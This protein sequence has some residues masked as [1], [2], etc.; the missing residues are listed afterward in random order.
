VRSPSARKRG[1]I[2]VKSLISIFLSS[3]LVLATPSCG[4]IAFQQRENQ[5]NTG[6]VDPNVV[7]MDSFWLL[8]F[9]APGVVAFAI[10]YA[11]DAIFLPASVAQGQGPFIKDAPTAASVSVK[12]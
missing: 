9:I 8:F 10:D 12:N 1:E 3:L 6:R 11:T 2:I 5:G 7:I 4:T